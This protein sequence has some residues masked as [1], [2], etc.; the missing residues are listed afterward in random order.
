M[1]EH[2]LG[3]ALVGAGGFGTFCLQAYRTLPTIKV[4]AVA[5]ADRQRAEMMAAQLGVP[6]CVTVEDVCADPAVDIVHLTTP[7]AHHAAQ[8]IMALRAGKHVLCEKPLA[9]AAGDAQAVLAVA[10]ATGCRVTVN[11]VLRHHPLWR[12]VAEIVR[13]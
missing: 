6:A 8:A 3:V 13:R 4:V 10:E 7:P 2:A 1:N 9:T 11:Y 5:D 12:L